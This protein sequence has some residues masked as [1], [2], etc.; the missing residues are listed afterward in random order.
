VLDVGSVLA[1]LPSNFVL[2]THLMNLQRL[3]VLQHEWEDK[4]HRSIDG[5]ECVCGDGYVPSDNGR[6]CLKIN[7]CSAS[8]ADL[9]PDC[10]CERCACHDIPGSANYE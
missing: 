7:Q 3:I 4:V 8:E 9:H 10:T 2:M 6:T 5:Y 1:F